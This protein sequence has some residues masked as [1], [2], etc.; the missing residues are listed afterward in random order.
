MM[1][2]AQ[3]LLPELDHELTSTHK[4]LE[5]IPVVYKDSVLNHIIHHRGQLPILLP[6]LYRPSADEAR[7]GPII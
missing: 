3:S 4:T 6:G 5:R 7:V 2:I 1:S